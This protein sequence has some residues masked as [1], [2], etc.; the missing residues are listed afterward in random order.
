V[1]DLIVCDWRLSIIYTYTTTTTT[2]TT[3]MKYSIRKASSS[4]TTDVHSSSYKKT[5]STSSSKKNKNKAKQ[6][7][8]V[9]SAPIRRLYKFGRTTATGGGKNKKDSNTSEQLEKALED[10]QEHQQQHHEIRPADTFDTE[11]VIS[12]VSITSLTAGDS[13]SYIHILENH[14]KEQYYDQIHEMV[15][16]ASLT[17]GDCSSYV[18]IQEQNEEQQDSIVGDEQSEDGEWS[19]LAEANLNELADMLKDNDE[20]SISTEDEVDSLVPAM[21]RSIFFDELED[22]DDVDDGDDNDDHFNPPSPCHLPTKRIMAAAA[23]VARP[24]VEILGISIN[25]GIEENHHEED[26]VSLASSHNSYLQAIESITGSISCNTKKSVGG[27]AEMY[28]SSIVTPRMVSEVDEEGDYKEYRVSFTPSN[29]LYLQAME[30]ASEKAKLDI[31]RATALA[32]SKINTVT[33]TASSTKDEVD[34]KKTKNSSRFAVA[35]GYTHN[36]VLGSLFFVFLIFNW[37][38]N[39]NQLLEIIRRSIKSNDA[40][41]DLSTTSHKHN[42][43]I[44]GEHSELST[45]I[46]NQIIGSTEVVLKRD[47]TVHNV[48]CA[49]TLPCLALSF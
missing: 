33:F 49:D 34:N 40:V 23:A 14:T 28:Q 13:F 37:S 32:L 24:P 12:P 9:F 19:D 44:A 41:V 17:L 16:M 48:A 45:W 20:E 2:T 4:E 25:Y 43:I 1:I 36:C 21:D 5:T 8:K 35:V 7:A 26:V 3:T 10:H 11:D 47:K 31:E 22:D 39:S 38:G 29:E 6:L 42:A 30:G 27:G 46:E 15:E 18:H